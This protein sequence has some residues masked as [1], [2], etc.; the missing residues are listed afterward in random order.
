[1]TS[2]KAETDDDDLSEEARATPPGL[3]DY[4]TP[5]GHARFS[6]ELRALLREERPR[7][8]DIV[9][10]AA[11]NG[12]RSENGDYQYGKKRL[13]EIDRRV[14]FLTKR[15]DRAKLV[16][17]AGQPN[18][19]QV[20]FGAT[21]TFIN[22]ED[23]ERSVTLVGVDEA[24]F[25]V[26]QVSLAS[27]IARALLGKRIGDEVPLRTPQGMVIIEVIAISYPGGA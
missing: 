16:D 10:W 25:T 17:P 21:V 3:R 27:P 24:D 13:R 8:V 11:G 6:A 18:R 2:R 23:E 12:D 5:D 9:S 4:I 26:G 14:R 20:F 22:E 1:M 7:I 19:G 15:L